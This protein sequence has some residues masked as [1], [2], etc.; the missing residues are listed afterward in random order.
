[1]SATMAQAANRPIP[2]SDILDDSYTSETT[3]ATSLKGYDINPGLD[4]SFPALS[5]QSKRFDFYE[6]TRLEFLWRPTS[7][8]TATKG[9]VI[10]AFDPNPNAREPTDLGE[11]MAYESVVAESIYKTVRLSVP[12]HMLRGR[13]FVRHGPTKDHLTL[14]DPGMLIIA[15]QGIDAQASLGVVEVHYTVKFSGYHLGGTT[16]F[17][18]HQIEVLSMDAS[19]TGIAATTATK[20]E[21]DVQTLGGLGGTLDT[22]NKRYTPGEGLYRISGLLSFAETTNGDTPSAMQVMMYK[23]GTVLAAPFLYIGLASGDSAEGGYDGITLSGYV[24]CDS[25]DYLEVW[26]RNNSANSAT[27]VDHTMSH[28]VIEAIN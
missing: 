27:T 16:A 13:R 10:L 5:F 21:L 12:P 4:S 18:P 14:F 1:M 6:F 22:T 15:N 23:N 28:V 24:E 3:F 2:G 20:L 25:D 17:A 26:V 9:M 7:A 11:I 8:I 19:Q